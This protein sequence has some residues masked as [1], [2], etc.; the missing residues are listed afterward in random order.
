MTDETFSSGFKGGLELSGKR[1]LFLIG[2]AGLE[3]PWPNHVFVRFVQPRA[4]LS[5][6]R[7]VGLN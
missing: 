6:M 1:R 4:R 7:G 5:S 3:A 2:G